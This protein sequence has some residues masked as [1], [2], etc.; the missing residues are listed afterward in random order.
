MSRLERFGQETSAT[1]T[2]AMFVLPQK[3]V[4]GP[5]KAKRRGLELPLGQKWRHGATTD[6]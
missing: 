6:H 3:T 1:N 5:A 2:T 4:F